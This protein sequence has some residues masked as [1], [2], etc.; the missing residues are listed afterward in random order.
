MKKL[1]FVNLFPLA[2][3]LFIIRFLA[4]NDYINSILFPSKV[5]DSQSCSDF[6]YIPNFID[7]PGYEENF[8]LND[9]SQKST[10]YLLG[11]SELTSES[12]AVP[13]K[14]ITNNFPVKIKAIGHAGNQSFSIYCQLLANE[15]RLNNTRIVFILSPGWFA[16]KYSKGTTSE[17]FLEYN[18]EQFLKN[19]FNGDDHFRDYAGKQIA[20]FYCEFNAPSLPLKLINFKYRS[21]VSL[22]HK[23]VYAPLIYLDIFLMNEKEAI[24][25]SVSKDKVSIPIQISYSINEKPIVDWDSLLTA[26]RL[27]VL[28]NATNNTIGVSNEYYSEH[29]NVNTG[30]VQPV[31]NIFNQELKDFK[32]LMKFIRTKNIDAFFIIQ[33][34]N[35]LYYNNL[36]TINPVIDEVREELRGNKNQKGYDFADFFVTDTTQF[37]RGILDDLMHFSNYGWYKVNQRIINHYNLNNEK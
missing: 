30:K 26:S 17:I 20:Q 9:S 3:V 37:D 35:P 5:E 7:N 21:S 23:I 2:I 34:L 33:P 28:L 10:I 32:M 31:K 18:S 4:H 36:A 27:H 22:L 29:L 14:F 25:N 19:I 6:N 8:L 13:Y 16:S 24:I 1:I 15:N 12:E 11:S